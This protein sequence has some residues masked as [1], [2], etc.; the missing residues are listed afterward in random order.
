MFQRVWPA[1]LRCAGPLIFVPWMLAGCGDD[2]LGQRY[3]VSGS[4]MRQGKPLT[5]GTVNFMPVD[6][7]KGRAA[8][9]DIQPDG[10]YSL[11]TQNR[12]DGALAGDYRV[13][14]SMVDIDDSKLGKMPNGMPILNRPDLVKVKNM[15]PPKYSDPS[16]TVLKF[17]VEPQ[18]N[19]F[20]IDLT[21]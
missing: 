10:S 7:S 14:I 4:V 6:P 5:K 16:K 2:E 17:K 1:W 12:D 15:V 20:P 11:T 9:G 19:T 3:S 13:V 21:E 18:N 8:T